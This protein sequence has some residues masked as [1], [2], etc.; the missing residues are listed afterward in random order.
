MQVGSVTAIS[1]PQDFDP[2]L[3]KKQRRLPSLLK[4]Q[5]LIS[6]NSALLPFLTVEENFF[7]GV[8]Q[9]DLRAYMAEFK[10]WQQLFKLDTALT[11]TYPADVSPE[12]QVIIQLMRAFTL[13]K[14][15]ILLDDISL[16]LSSDFLASIMPILK[17][18]VRERQV[19]LIILTQ[20]EDLAND[21]HLIVTDY[22]TLIDSVSK[23]KNTHDST[24]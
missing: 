14:P 17:K 10:A 15:V 4:N 13:A 3:E 9:K 20:K 7:V 11:H 18:I 2:V 22:R 16:N 1:F 23:Q 19:A 21:Y 8:K 6:A 24:P 5:Y 12:T